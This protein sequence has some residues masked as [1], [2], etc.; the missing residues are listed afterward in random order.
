MI[1]REVYDETLEYFGGDTLAT[2]VWINKYSLK[3]VDEKTNEIIYHEKT[4]TDMFRR[5]SKEFARIENKYPNPLSEEE[6]FELLKNFKYVVPQGGPMSGIGNDFQV[7]SLSN[8]FVIGNKLDSYGSIF[9][10]D[11][12]QVQLMKRRGGVGHDLSYLRP[13]GTKVKNSALTSTGVVPFMERYSNSTKEV[14]QDGRRG[15][16]LLSISIKHP[17]SESFIDAKLIEGKVTGANISVKLDDEFMNS[18]FSD[19]KYIQ[20]F[21]IDSDNPIIEKEIDSK[22]VWKKIVYNA[23]KSAEPGV[24]FLD[25]IIRESLPDCYS[26]FGFD[27]ISGNP[28]VS[29]DTMIMTNV[30]KLTVKEIF[31]RFN[32]GEKFIIDSFNVK[33]SKL[34]KDE[35]DD[36]LLTKRNANTIEL[37]LEDNPTLVLT[38]DHRVFTKNRGWVQACQLSEED[39][40]LKID[41]KR[42]LYIFYSTFIKNAIETKIKKI[43][44][45]KNENVYDLKVRKN[46]NFFANNLLVHNCSEIFMGLYATC[47]L[48]TNNLYSYVID[49]FTVDAR[50][51]FDLFKNN[52]KKAQR[53][54]DDLVDLELEKIDKIIAKIKKDPEPKEVKAIELN[55]WQKIREKII[56]SRRTG[57]GITA[58]GDMLAAMGLVYGTKE[59]TEFATLVQREFAISAYLSDTILAKERGTF[60]IYDYELEQNNPFLQRLFRES[61][62]LKNAVKECGRRNIACLTI[63]PAGSLSVLTKTTSGIEPAFLISYKRRRK[64]NPND[65]DAKVDFVDNEGISWEEY[66]VFHHKFEV[67][68]EVNGYNVAEVKKYPD[69]K[70]K[71]IIEKSPYHNATTSDVDWVEKVRMQGELQKYID[72][73]ISATTNLPNSATEELVSQVYEMAWRSGCKGHTVYRDGSRQGVLISNE[74]KP[75]DAEMITKT[76]APKR[77][78]K[79]KCNIHHVTA[80]GQ[81]WVVLVGMINSNTTPL[82]PYEVFAFKKKNIDISPKITSGYLIRIKSGHYILETEFVTLDKIT[83]LFEQDEEEALTR[84][85]SATLRHGADVR[86]I[87]E[88]LNKSEGT[89]ASFGKAIARSL[90]HYIDDEAE[91]GGEVCPKCGGKLIYQEG[92]VKCS[93]CSW[94]KCS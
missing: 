50:F 12:E 59:A 39:I 47:I 57:L 23:W 85:V 43:N 40:L 26:D 41:E 63:S 90:K 2:D 93:M 73:N 21:P 45:H 3:E 8:C 79:L 70:L 34:E 32:N 27:S 53:L 35:I 56:Q 71:L 62:K 83:E 28:C 86:F 72:H 66:N 15:A 7:T 30:G 77:P 49:P 65:K 1:H 84:M 64:I 68:L 29:G 48:I 11:Q 19:G 75:R 58:E 37:I 69:S 51:D 60:P 81:D 6:I 78:K 25:N 67:W 54:I 24:L 4:P 92:C 74:T 14:A 20:Q 52:I 42:E 55:L 13:K 18:V 44:I 10:T 9:Q 82:T 88:Q 87:V 80:K 16:A 17:D 33:E 61:S 89:V 76:S 46:N 31:E 5:L 94:S 38:P 36:I 22:I 91:V